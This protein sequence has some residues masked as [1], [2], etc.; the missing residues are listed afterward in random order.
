MHHRPAP[1]S[2]PPG[3]QRRIV[4]LVLSGGHI[5]CGRRHVPYND[6]GTGFLNKGQLSP[7]PDVQQLR[8]R[9]SDW[10]LTLLTALVVLM[11]FVF[12]P[13]QALGI[14]AFQGFAIAGLLVV[15]IGVLIMSASRI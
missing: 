9:Y 11:I 5:V 4:A 13:L 15:I 8:S 7:G 6:E 3:P 12:A 1:P 14:Y 10:L 2:S